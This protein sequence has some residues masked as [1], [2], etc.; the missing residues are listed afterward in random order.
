MSNSGTAVV[1]GAAGDIGQ[2]IVVRLCREQRISTIATFHSTPSAMLSSAVWIP[3][4]TLTDDCTA[5]ENAINEIGRPLSAI[6]YCIGIPSSKLSVTETS[7]EEWI[8]LFRVNCVGFAQ[9]YGALRSFARKGN[10]SVVV[11][12]SDT[13]RVMGPKNGAYSA[14]K[15]A[16]EAVLQTL[17]KEEAPYGVRINALAPSLV[18]S[19]LADKVLALKEV[20]NRAAYVSSQ[21]W[22]R[23]LALDEVADAALWLAFAP[24][25]KYMTGQV[26][27]L[28]A[29]L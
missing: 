18:A 13:T 17:A 2:A 23:L 20:E 8:K 7:V 5:I 25:S 16:L 15:V 3:Y 6:F 19:S 10:A 9:A 11:L 22:G 29:S 27:R 28:T 1:F 4:D 26:I 14:S 24:G 21:P 12:S